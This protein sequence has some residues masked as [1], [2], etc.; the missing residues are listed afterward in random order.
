MGNTADLIQENS[1][2]PLTCWELVTSFYTVFEVN[3]DEMKPKKVRWQHRRYF[4]RVA[5]LAHYLLK[6]R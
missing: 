3:S 4:L 5:P 1:Q 6:K 2:V